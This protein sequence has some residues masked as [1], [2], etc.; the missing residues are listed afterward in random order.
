M[1]HRRDSL[2]A[3]VFRLTRGLMADE[4]STR[5][6]ML[7]FGEPLE[8]LLPNFASETPAAG[9]L[10]MPHAANHPA[11]AVVVLARVLE[12]L[13]VITARLPCAQRLRDREHGRALLE[14]EWL[15]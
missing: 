1:L 3:G 8:V 6:R 11:F 14:E 4:L 13:L 10:A 12:F 9:E 15:L 7:T 2:A 5:N